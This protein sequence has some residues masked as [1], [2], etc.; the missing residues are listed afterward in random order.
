MAEK[1]LLKLA[2]GDDKKKTTVTKKPTE[3]KVEKPISPAEERD[4]K[5]KQKVQELLKDVDLKP[6]MKEEIFEIEEEKI[7]KPNGEGMEWLQEQVSLLSAKCENLKAEL[8]VA[9]SDYAKILSEYQ[10]LMNSPT[11]VDGNVKANIIRIFDELQENHL[12][13]GNNF[14][15][16]PVAFM[17]RLVMF[18][19]FLAEHKRF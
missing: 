5:A 7:E 3:K 9:K 16:Y 10:Q 1:N 8:E 4:M 6:E 13:M 19:P 18:F 2:K 17:N 12:N 14:I 15:I 11:T